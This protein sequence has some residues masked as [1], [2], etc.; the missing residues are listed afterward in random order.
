MDNKYDYIVI[1]SGPAGHVSAIRAHQLGL[2]TAVIEKN[3]QEMLGG[4]CLNEGCIPA[5][6]LF[7]SVKIA[8]KIKNNGELYNIDVSGGKFNIAKA[9]EKSRDIAENLKKGLT[10]LFKKN[11]I[12]LIEGEAKLKTNKVV[13]VETSSGEKKEIIADKVL[14]ATGSK[15][16]ALP[17]VPFDG[18]RIITSSE[19]IRLKTI[20]ENILILG[21]GAIGTEFASYF[22]MAGSE[23]TLL[24]LE[25]SIVPLEDKEISK[26]FSSVLKRNG[27]KIMTSSSLS[28]VS[29]E[30]YEYILVAVGR[31]P[32]TQ[33]IG[34]E[35]IGV[36][37]DEKGFI[38]VNK[39][40]KT[41]LDNIYAAGD[42]I[43][44]PML[45]HAGYK[46][47]EFAA[48]QIVGKDP[49]AIDY[50]LIPNAIYTGPQVASI[51]IT[52][53][54]AKKRN[55][56]YSVGKQL[57]KSSG[58]AVI[59]GQTEGFIKIIADTKTHE[60]L[61]VHILGPE[62]SELIHEFIVA[63]AA[64]LTVEEI[65]E[66]VHAHPTLSELAIDACRAVFDKPIH[67]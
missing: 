60:V 50:G 40:L 27:I 14:I 30:D 64:G 4:V 54:E 65:S 33:G 58:K 39:D 57:F 13:V 67:G 29:M 43:K 16:K 52:E 5:K 25:D 21:A 38:E 34:L 32:S 10:F 9:V 23:V 12:D 49:K 7:D 36:K 46:E 56:D 17:S 3:I 35:E 37:V 59:I 15:P 11:N 20:P 63:M 26:R 62:A 55:I 19:A 41:S 31:T 24:E 44:G 6:S 8:D 42:V 47:G 22:N 66:I 48:E 51:G 53:E 61:G 45:A 18:K 1:G 2:K 28:D